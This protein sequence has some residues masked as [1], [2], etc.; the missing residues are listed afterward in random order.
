MQD[1]SEP[2]LERDRLLHR[3]NK[4]RDPKDFEN[5]KSKADQHAPF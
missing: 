5:V 4:H 1:R 3:I 2:N